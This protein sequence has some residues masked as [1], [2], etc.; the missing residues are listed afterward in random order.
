MLGIYDDV[1]KK[2]CHKPKP[3]IKVLNKSLVNRNKK[4][5]Q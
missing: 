1:I 4:D 2:Y 5:P 3:H